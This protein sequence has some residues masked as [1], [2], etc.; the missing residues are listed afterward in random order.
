MVGG[1]GLPAAHPSLGQPR[2]QALRGGGGG[3]GTPGYCQVM[4][5]AV[6]SPGRDHSLLPLD[7]QVPQGWVTR[8]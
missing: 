6:F 8:M 2:I 1:G 7:R 5:G 4:A 3:G